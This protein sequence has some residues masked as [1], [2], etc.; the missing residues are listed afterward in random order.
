MV[1]LLKNNMKNKFFTI[2]QIIATL[3]ALFFSASCAT[4]TPNGQVVLPKSSSKQSET[5]IAANSSDVLTKL[6]FDYNE[7]DSLINEFQKDP[8]WTDGELTM[9]R[10]NCRKF[11]LDESPNR[12][13]FVIV[14]NESTGDISINGRQD[15]HDIFM[16]LPTGYEI[17]SKSGLYSQVKSAIQEAKD[18][19][20]YNLVFKEIRNDD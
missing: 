18:R 4:R 16:M 6:L 5:V 1:F 13:E 8:Y 7:L 19:G 15:L 10:D 11:L 2:A 9:F 17:S 20:I 3:G 12:R 14:I